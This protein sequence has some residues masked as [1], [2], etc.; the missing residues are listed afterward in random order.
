M[1]NPNFPAGRGGPAG[2][3]YAQLAPAP[4]A[5]GTNEV[6]MAQATENLRLLHIVEQIAQAAGIVVPAGLQANVDAYAAD[7]ERVRQAAAATATREK[8]TRTLQPLTRVPAANYGVV[9]DVANIRLYSIKPYDGTDGEPKEVCRWIQRVL[10]L[11]HT[12]NLTLAATLILLLQASAGEVTDYI[13][14]LRDEGNGLGEVIRALELRYGDLCLPEEAIQKCNTMK[15]QANE[16]LAVFLDRLRYQ[17][18]MAKRMI[19]DDDTRKLAVNT[20]IESNIRR[21]LPGSVR[22]QLEE[23]VL[24][25]TR[26]G[27]P[28]FTTRELEKE[29]QELERRRDERRM[30][31]S[32]PYQ[33]AP[34]PA[35]GR[36]R[37]AIQACQ[38]DE[39]Y[40]PTERECSSSDEVNSETE[41]LIAEIK[42]QAKKYQGKGRRF[43]NAKIL[44]KVQKKFVKRPEAPVRPVATATTAQ[45]LINGPPL[46]IPEQ[47]QQ[48]MSIP[49]LLARANCERG[50]CIH[51][52]NPGHYMKRE[53]CPLLGKPI[54]DRAC[55]VCKKGLH[56]ADDCLRVFQKRT[57]AAQL[58]ESD[59]SDCL[60]EQ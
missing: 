11:A 60:N 32:N 30:E 28:A 6:L 16:P 21:V 14:E 33:R 8:S 52:G 31:A 43:N 1:A 7:A 35:R 51:C 19:D 34:P 53:G 42:Y 25:R 41:H 44:D 3:G 29:C 10:N 5:L 20:L 47:Q 58:V 13:N 9:A 38:L 17:A 4:D 36:H 40:P 24:A 39:G 56:A 54:V 46:R 23:R 49:E 50:E 57:G 2:G 26:S 48:R 45:V 18:R 27:L 12:H 22:N 15:R 55:P 59:D 37:G